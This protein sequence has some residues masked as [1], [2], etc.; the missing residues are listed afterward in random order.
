VE[1]LLDNA[2]W[3]RLP[4]R[5][6]AEL[7]AR[8]AAELNAV[9]L[10]QRALQVRNGVGQGTDGTVHPQPAAD[11]V[12]RSGDNRY[13]HVHAVPVSEGSKAPEHLIV[14]VHDVTKEILQQQKLAAIHQAGQELSD[15]TTEELSHMSI[16]ERIKLLKSNILHYT[17]DLLHFDVVEI[18][19]MDQKTNRLEPLLAVG[20]Q[21]EAEQRVL[22]ALPQNNGVTGYVVQ[23]GDTEQLATSLDTLL[24][25]PENARRMGE[26]G[27]QRV[28]S[29]YRFNTFSK[30]FKKILRELCES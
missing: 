5:V 2:G 23:H 29:E 19:L 25:N 9:H 8:L 12:L 14:T 27:R 28:E 18:R 7:L 1:N 11:S 6:P 4:S 20:M 24:S 30:A 17:K 22:F 10:E 26:A 13:F 3:E 15:L 21:P 16:D